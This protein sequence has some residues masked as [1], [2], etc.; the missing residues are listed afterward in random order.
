MARLGG[1]IYNLYLR[2]LG[3]KIGRNTV[4]QSALGPVCTDLISI[5]SNTI[6]RKD[7]IVLG[8]KAQSNFIHTGPI[9]VGANAFV[10]E[11]SVLDINTT[12]EDDTQLGHSS[13]LQERPAHSARQAFSRLSGAARRRPIIARSSQ[14]T[15]RRCGALP[16]LSCS[17][18]AGFAAC[19]RCRC[20]SSTGCSRLSTTNSSARPRSPTRR[21]RRS[22]VARGRQD[23]ADL[24][25]LLHRLSSRSD[26]SASAS[27][28]RL[29]TCSCGRTKPTSSTAS[30]ISSS[31]RSRR[32]ATRRSSTACSATARRSSIGAMARL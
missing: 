11:A 5:G 30:T 10:G 4:I 26:C 12:M 23:A 2:L 7:S 25:R 20:W 19:C 31:R 17:L 8:Y 1:P 21:L 18:A 22:S 9:N 27:F 28:R 3:A 15:A 13:S 32:S 16:T 14:G 6:L 24:V 29:S